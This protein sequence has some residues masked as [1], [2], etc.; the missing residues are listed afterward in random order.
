MCKQ[1]VFFPNNGELLESQWRGIARCLPTNSE[2]S[3]DD[4]ARDASGGA[5]SDARRADERSGEVCERKRAA[6]VPR[7]V[8]GQSTAAVDDWVSLCGR[9]VRVLDDVDASD[10]TGR[11]SNL[12]SRDAD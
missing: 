8:C 7:V 4:D 6:L 11:R 5:P 1:Y 12:A 2:N 9:R 10:A 3:D